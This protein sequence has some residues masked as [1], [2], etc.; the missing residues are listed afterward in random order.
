MVCRSVGG[1]ERF[2]SVIAFHSYLLAD[3]L[4][5]LNLLG[6][7]LLSACHDV[8]RHLIKLLNALPLIS[9]GQTTAGSHV[10]YTRKRIAV[11]PVVAD[12]RTHRVVNTD[13]FVS[14]F[15]ARMR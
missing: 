10:K 5:P 9:Y 15:A 7:A 11:L 13:I 8:P 14:V 3:A 12:A 4:L 1:Y 2:P 6:V